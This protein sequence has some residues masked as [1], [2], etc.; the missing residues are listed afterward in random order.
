MFG[1]IRRRGMRAIEL[2][3]GEGRVF[4]GGGGVVIL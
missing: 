4:W 2:G 3:R 1:G